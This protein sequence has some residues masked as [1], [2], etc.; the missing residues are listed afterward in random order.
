MAKASKIVRALSFI[1]NEMRPRMSLQR[2]KVCRNC[3]G[4]DDVQSAAEK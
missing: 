4:A 1:T 2:C 3:E